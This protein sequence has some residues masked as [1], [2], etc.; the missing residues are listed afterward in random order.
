MA[1]GSAMGGPDTTTLGGDMYPVGD[2][3]EASADRSEVMST[4]YMY[5]S[6]WHGH[7]NAW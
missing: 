3:D 6:I 2:V 4:G 1:F 7:P 5:F